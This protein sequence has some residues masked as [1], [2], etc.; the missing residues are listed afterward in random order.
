MGLGDHHGG[1]RRPSWWNETFGVTL[2]MGLGHEKGLGDKRGHGA[3][4][5]AGTRGWDMG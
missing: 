5:W 4:T 2:G 1:F 3:A